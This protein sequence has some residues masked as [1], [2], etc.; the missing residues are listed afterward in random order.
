MSD[1]LLLIFVITIFIRST[2]EDILSELA[3]EKNLQMS[4]LQIGFYLAS[5][6]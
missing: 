2:K 4:C 1:M 3:N 6:E 5:W